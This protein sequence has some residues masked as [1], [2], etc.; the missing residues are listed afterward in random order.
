M[1]TQTYHHVELKI[2][3]GELHHGFTCTAPEDAP[4]RR[5]PKDHEQRDSWSCDESTEIGFPCWAVDWV[6]AVGIEDAI[7]GYPDQVLARVPV[8]I[9]YEECVSIE[10]ITPELSGPELGEV[11]RFGIHEEDQEDEQ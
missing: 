3:S 2:E 4:C 9:S 7:F 8:T 6:N 11:T 10:P 1:S 5:R